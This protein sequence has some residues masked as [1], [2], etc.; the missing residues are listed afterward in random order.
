MEKRV[1]IKYKLGHSYVFTYEK[2]DLYCPSCGKQK[3]WVEQGSGD[4]YVGAEYVCTSCTA[5]FHL[6][7]LGSNDKSY[8]GE[9]MIKQL[10]S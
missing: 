4:Y 2:T 9:Q 5:S 6:P 1:T 8:T 3:V 7:T 10:R